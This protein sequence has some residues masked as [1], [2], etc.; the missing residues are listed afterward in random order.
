MCT[1][2]LIVMLTYNDLT[3]KNAFE[4]FDQ[5]KNSNA[6]YWGLKEKGLPKNQMKELF[7]FMKEKNKCTVL[8]V[9][10]YSENEGLEGAKLAFDCGCDIL[11]GTVFSDS[12]N[13][14]CLSHNLKYMPFIGDVS[15]RPSVLNG[16]IDEMIF[17]A[18]S[19]IGKGV[20]GI[21]LLGYRFTGNQFEL[22]KKIVEKVSSP[23]CIAGSIDSYQ[24]LDE[25]KKI[26]PWA[27]TI[28]SAFF[29]KKFG[30]NFSLQIET[31]LNYVLNPPHK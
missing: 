28:G 30:E 22:N 25:I 12:I 5:C 3:V 13:E 23:I 19:Y 27:F 8:E 14:F 31:V 4:I 15:E 9:V 24:R 20:F 7:S 18:Q 6:K 21:D 26:N 29:E 2:E 10:A 1:S 16:R 17:Q 11:M